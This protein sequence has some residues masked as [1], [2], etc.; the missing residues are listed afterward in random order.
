M[1]PKLELKAER[2]IFIGFFIAQLFVL[3]V[4]PWI[5]PNWN[6]QFLMVGLAALAS[7][8]AYALLWAAVE[9]QQMEGDAL[10]EKIVQAYLPA[11][12]VNQ[13]LRTAAAAYDDICRME[14]E[15]QGFETAQYRID[16]VK[17]RVAA[18]KDRFWDRHGLAHDMGYQVMPKV[19]DYLE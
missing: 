15:L 11:E 8:F 18:A 3:V 19:R 12:V 7:G 1:V 4:V 9:R 5:W 17:A 10:I 14:I 2:N 16:E 13:E 6:A